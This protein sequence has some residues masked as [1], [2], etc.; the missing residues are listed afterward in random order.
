MSDGGI[1]K[2]LE[3]WATIRLSGDMD[4]PKIKEVMG[5]I[6]GILNEAG[7][8]GQVVHATRMS[9]DPNQEPVV[10]VSLRDAK[11]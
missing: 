7:V 1:G 4:S 8:N 6:R 3:Y 9:V 11:E 2:G 5:R 10:S